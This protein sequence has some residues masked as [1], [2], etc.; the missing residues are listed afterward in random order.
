MTE[1]LQ[2]AEAV[3]VTDYRGLTVAQFRALRRALRAVG[4]EIHVIK[5]SLTTRALAAAG[6]ESPEQLLHGPTALALFGEDLSG[7]AKALLAAVEDTKLLSIKGGLLGGRVIDAADVEAL[8]KL[9]TRPELLAILLGTI[10]APQRQFVTV[11]QAPL[12]DMVGVLNAY[13]EKQAA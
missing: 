2:A 6:L 12:V 5:N 3:V 13:T 1:Q 4:A 7:P 9:P 11:L 8:S 10:M